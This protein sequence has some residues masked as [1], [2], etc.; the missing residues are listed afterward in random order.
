MCVASGTYCRRGG[1]AISKR[2]RI[3]RGRSNRLCESNH[4]I[5]VS[6]HSCFPLQ[7]RTSQERMS[8]PQL[9][10]EAF[11]DPLFP[12]KLPFWINIKYAST[13]APVL[14]L[15]LPI[16]RAPNNPKRMAQTPEHAHSHPC[17]ICPGFS[18]WPRF[19]PKPANHCEG[20]AR[21]IPN[22][23]G[24][25]AGPLDWQVQSERMHTAAR[26]EWWA[27]LCLQPPTM[28]AESGQHGQRW[29]VRAHKKALVAKMSWTSLHTYVLCLL[30]PSLSSAKSRNWNSETGNR[31]KG[32][33]IWISTDTNERLRRF[34]I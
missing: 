33:T 16:S 22:R 11:L 8:S 30:T 19:S 26:R 4:C 32:D 34:L 6:F 5:A 20:T 17:T 2:G 15:V 23:H 18:N 9:P 14:A 31:L 1:W 7:N 3:S 29:M 10:N 12:H 24:L 27:R 21:A 28:H 13:S 25:S